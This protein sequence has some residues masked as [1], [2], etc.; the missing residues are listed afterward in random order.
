[1]IQTWALSL[2]HQVKSKISTQAWSLKSSSTARI[3]YRL[4]E[5]NEWTKVTKLLLHGLR[6]N[7]C[8]YKLSKNI[9]SSS[10]VVIHS[11]SRSWLTKKIWIYR[12]FKVKDCSKRSSV[13]TPMRRRKSIGIW[14]LMWSSLQSCQNR[15]SSSSAHYHLCQSRVL[16]ANTY[17]LW[18]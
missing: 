16:W 9:S 12:K 7:Y 2:W 1:M 6:S 8:S 3:R 17:S 4:I 13:A 11:K 18:R 15:H 5:K 14:H 10:R